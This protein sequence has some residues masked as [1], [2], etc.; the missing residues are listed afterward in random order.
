MS[1][2]CIETA[3]ILVYVQQNGIIRR[4]SDHFIIGHLSNDVKFEEL[5]NTPSRESVENSNET[6]VKLFAKIM[7][8]GDWKW[9]TPNERVIEMLMRNCGYYPFSTED[10]M[11][12]NTAVDESLF[13][14][15]LTEVPTRTP[16]AMLRENEA[17]SAYIPTAEE[18]K[19]MQKE[20]DER[21][22]EVS[23]LSCELEQ[24]KTPSATA[25][26]ITE[27]D[28][29]M[30]SILSLIGINQKDDATYTQKIKI[31]RSIMAL[32]HSQQATVDDAAV[33]YFIT[34][35]CP[36]GEDDKRFFM[37]NLAR[38]LHSQQEK[39]YT[40]EEKINLREEKVNMREEKQFDSEGK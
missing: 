3:S 16:I 4:E 23:G 1:D 15:A 34:Q 12:A 7:F 11:I 37:D 8:Y 27:F 33:K 32:F 24:L 25:D 20:Y 5:N 19:Q 29:P 28:E 39:R 36:S 13:K 35:H 9:E 17:P 6:I 26:D 2:T 21:C 10:E 38:L 31:A 30:K 22:Q 14:R 40:R 18:W